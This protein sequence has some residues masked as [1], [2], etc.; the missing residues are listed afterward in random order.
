MKEW[1]SLNN[2]DKTSQKTQFMWL[3]HGEMRNVW[4]DTWEKESNVWSHDYK[5]ESTNELLGPEL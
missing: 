5:A 3:Q 4:P 1:L 2:I